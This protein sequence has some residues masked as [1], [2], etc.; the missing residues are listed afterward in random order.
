MGHL[1]V[2][3]AAHA[4]CQAF[5]QLVWFVDVTHAAVCCLHNH[6]AFSHYVLGIT[7]ATALLSLAMDEPVVSNVA[8]T[9]EL[10]L[11]GKVLKI[12]GVKEKVIAARRSGVEQII[13]PHANQKD[14][15]EL[16]DSLVRDC[17]TNPMLDRCTYNLFLCWACN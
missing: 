17:R 5:L 9:G 16:P 3:A 6:V 8:M 11:T 10:S 4:D 12:G 14:W 13:M 1:P 2:S 15:E 7:M